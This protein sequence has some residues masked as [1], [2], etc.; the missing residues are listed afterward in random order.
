MN[1]KRDPNLRDTK[2]DIFQWINQSTISKAMYNTNLERQNLEGKEVLFR[3][4]SK[5]PETEFSVKNVK[6]LR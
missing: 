2:P 5:E 6:D 4:H 3:R 1:H